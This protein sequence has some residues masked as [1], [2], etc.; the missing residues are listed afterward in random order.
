M[1]Y[2]HFTVYS[3]DIPVAI[4]QPPA[5]SF[6]GPIHTKQFD[7]KGGTF[8]SP[9]HKVSIVVPPNSIDDGEKVTVHMGATTSGPFDLPEDCKLRSAVVWL[10][11]ESDVVLKRSITV[12]I[13]HSAVLTC[14]QN[15]SMMKFL[16]CED[17]EG[18]RYKFKCYSVDFF[19]IDEDQG[20]IELYRFAMV[21]IAA[22]SEARQTESDEEY[23]DTVQT[24]ESSN[25]PQVAV[26]SKEIKLSIPPARYLAKVFWPHGQL[27]KSFK[28][29]IF[30]LQNI[31]TEIY[32]VKLH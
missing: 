29:D 6:T 31:P 19:E 13:P 9:V 15:C 22:S 27:P 26:S 17:F 4:N 24:I 3:G 21:A 11:S 25:T 8:Q 18:P 5:V 16:T 28:A 2:I 20:S 14:P 10:G 23:Q 32:K 1:Y 12:V 30:Y 7:H